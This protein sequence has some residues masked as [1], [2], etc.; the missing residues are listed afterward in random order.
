MAMEEKKPQE[1]RKYVR[2]DVKTKVNFRLTKKRDDEVVLKQLSGTTK[3]ISVEGICF[4][5]ET[6]LEPGSKLEL[7]VVLPGEPEPLLLRG[8][9][10]WVYP[11]QSGQDK[12][13]YD[14]GV[15]LFTIDKG[16]ENRFMGY[17]CEKMTERLSRYLHL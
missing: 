12:E 1:R 3:N 11:V 14:T 10:K 8:E 15:R 16:D 6:K 13:T 9:V 7:E 4:T 17:V 5:S 2:F